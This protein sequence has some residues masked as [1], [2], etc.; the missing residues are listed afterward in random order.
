[1]HVDPVQGWYDQ[2]GF[3]LEAG[4]VTRVLSPNAT[5]V[6][7]RTAVATAHPD[8]LDLAEHFGRSH[9][10]DRLRVASFEARALL[11]QKGEGRDELWR[12]AELSGNLLLAQTA[13]A[14]R[15][16]LGW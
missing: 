14:K 7:L 12:E 13:Q 10:S 11:L 15:A 8:V 1:M 16:Q 9:P 3:D 6:F 2:Y 5:E 4:E